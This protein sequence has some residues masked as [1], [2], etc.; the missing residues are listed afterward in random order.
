MIQRTDVTAF[1]ISPKS[2]GSDMCRWKLGRTLELGKLLAPLSWLPVKLE[3]LP[4]DLRDR[5]HISFVETECDFASS[6]KKL[7]SEL[8]G[9]SLWNRTSIALSSPQAT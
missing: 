5:Q 2:V 3:Q 6:L 8:S 4:Q 1:V 9:V 7:L